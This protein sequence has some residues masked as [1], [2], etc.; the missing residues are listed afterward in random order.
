MVSINPVLVIK[1]T[2]LEKEFQERTYKPLAVVQ[3]IETCKELVKIFN[4]KNIEIT[5]IGFDPLDS[6]VK[7]ETFSEQVISG[8]FHP[9]FR[10]LVESSLWYDVI[11]NK[12]K[13]L[14]TKV[15]QVEVTI[16][17]ED[18]NNVIGYKNENIEKLKD[19]YDVELVVTTD[20]TMKRGKS[21]ID[22]TKVF[23]SE[24]I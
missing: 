9:E 6:E 23:G 2:S 19:T 24:E 21:K 1:N 12:I 22:I 20:E 11:V 15:M 18:V 7:Q 10:Q 4:K 14:N 13:M 8:P 3:A 16:N 17:P 5:A